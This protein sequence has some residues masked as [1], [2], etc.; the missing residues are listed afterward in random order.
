MTGPASLYCLLHTHRTRV[1][2]PQWG[3]GNVRKYDKDNDG[4]DDSLKY[5]YG[6][7]DSHKKANN[8][9]SDSKTLSSYVHVVTIEN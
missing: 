4:D 7:K 6:Q 9:D 1:K 2:G 8:K 5:Q 3:L